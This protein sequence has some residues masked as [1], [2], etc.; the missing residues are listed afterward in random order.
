MCHKHNIWMMNLNIEIKECHEKYYK[1]QEVE[2]SDFAQLLPCVSKPNENIESKQNAS[3][4]N[5]HPSYFHTEHQ[6]DI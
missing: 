5:I 3:T 6:I 2:E 1:P 4:Q